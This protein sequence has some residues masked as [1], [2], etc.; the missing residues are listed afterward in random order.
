MNGYITFYKDKSHEVWAN[1]SYE[2]Q[3]K[4]AQLFK[5]KRSYDVTVVLC[6]RRDGTTV[7]HVGA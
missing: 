1:N 6:E 7:T 4:A 2:A 3:Q 5:A